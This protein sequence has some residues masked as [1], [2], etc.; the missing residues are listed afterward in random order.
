MSDHIGQINGIA[1]CICHWISDPNASRFKLFLM[2]EQVDDELLS[3]AYALK[4]E[5]DL[6]FS[7]FIIFANKLL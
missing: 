5:F 2:F 1:L 7:R 3:V 4:N 6:N